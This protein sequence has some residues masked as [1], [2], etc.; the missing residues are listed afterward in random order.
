MESLSPKEE[1]QYKEKHHI[2]VDGVLYDREKGIFTFDFGS[3]N[4]S[5]KVELLP[6]THKIDAFGRCFYYSYECSPG[7]YTILISMGS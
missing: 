3:D 7:A 6:Q 1:L 4:Q 2:V 5:N